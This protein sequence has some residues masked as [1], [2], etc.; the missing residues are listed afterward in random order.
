M[1]W[2]FV[3]YW[4]RNIL[5]A[6]TGIIRDGRPNCIA[7]ALHLGLLSCPRDF[8][9]KRKSECGRFIVYDAFRKGDDLR[10]SALER[11]SLRHVRMFSYVPA[12]HSTSSAGERPSMIFAFHAFA[13]G[14]LG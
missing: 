3:S 11:S 14:E 6:I 4:R 7:R 10:A 13:F 1:V 8:G 12:Y 9:R 2:R 5:R